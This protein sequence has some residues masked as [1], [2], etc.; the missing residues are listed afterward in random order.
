MIKDISKKTLTRYIMISTILFIYFLFIS[1]DVLSKT[2]VTS[3]STGLK[4]LTIILFFITSLT[5]DSATH[6]VRNLRLLQFALF[7]T[8]CADTCLLVFD[9]YKPGIFFFCIVQ[10]LYIIRHNNIA[11]IDKNKLLIP[12]ILIIVLP[13][14]LS[15]IRP[16][17]VEQGLYLIAIVYSVLLITG[18]IIALNSTRTIAWGMTFF[19]LCD[20]NVALSFIFSVYPVYLLG[21]PLDYICGFLVWVF[22]LPSQLLLTLSG[23]ENEKLHKF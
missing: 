14:A 18:L 19:F 13:I 4:Y 10:T 7:F 9:Y 17:K 12:I 16:V 3:Y 2:T 1:L 23:F 6:N 8:L 15:K 5:I 11:N 20:T 22:Y 21:I